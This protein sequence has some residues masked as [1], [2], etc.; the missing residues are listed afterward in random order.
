MATTPA[1]PSR[2]PTRILKPTVGWNHKGRAVWFQARTAWPTAEPSAVSRSDA[3][4]HADAMPRFVSA[5]RRPASWTPLG[6]TNVGGRITSLVVHPVD[7]DRLWVGAANGGVWASTDGGTTWRAQWS[8]QESLAIGA[9]AIDPR[10]PNI[11]YAA[12][13]EANSSADS[14]PGM[15]LYRS[16]NGGRSWTLWAD[17]REVRIPARIGA[18]VVSPRDSARLW[19]GGL[20]FPVDD[21]QGL[22]RSTDGGRTWSH[23]KIGALDFCWCRSV[24]LDP[25]DPTTIFVGVTVR[26]A[27][28]GIYRSRD[29]GATWERL[30]NGLPPG[31]K[32]DRIALAVAPSD[33]RVLYAQISTMRS[34]HLGIF[35][36][37]DG[38]D[39]WVDISGNEFGQ[40]RQ[41]QY[42]NTVAV[43]P[44]NPDWVLAGGVDLHLSRDG[45]MTW[46]QVTDWRARRGEPNY[47]HADQHAIVM[48]AAAAGRVYVGNDGGIDVSQDGGQTWAN[49][50][51]G[52]AITMFYDL[53][54]AQTDV[55]TFGG[56]CQDNGTNI[57]TDGTAGGFFDI[58]G[59]DGGWM[60]IDPRDA[61]HLIA[62]IYNGRIFRWIGEWEDISLPV[63]PDEAKRVWMV[64]IA[65]DPADS[66]V[67]VTGTFRVWRTRDAGKTWVPVSDAL[68]D[69]TISA[70]AFAPSNSLRLY[71]G[72]EN[73]GIFRSS[74]GGDSWTENLAGNTVPEFLI[75]R[76]AVDPG[77]PDVVY[78]T[79]ANAGHR[80]L[81]RSRDAGDTWEDADRGRLP[82]ISH[83]A[84]L[85][86]PDDPARLFVA[87]DVG[88]FTS[89]DAGATWQNLSG[90]LPRTMVTDLVLHRASQRLIAATYGRSLYALS[91]AAASPRAS[92]A[93]EGVRAAVAGA[94]SRRRRATRKGRGARSSRT[95]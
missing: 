40:E 78:A 56:G 3:L 63:P 32:M 5:R 59:G 21:P 82:D 94:R 9:M 11:L 14:Y 69:S 57:T 36:S 73:G 90:N 65:M 24:V 86:H 30:T 2:L 23:V 43:H 80:H 79:V 92:R 64:F 42:N 46:L 77:N 81:F 89:E 8:E 7:P 44:N 4:E 60:V 47:A 72:T 49:R 31:D 39:H 38:G 10:N 26:S 22:Y 52:L 93:P 85:I 71:V 34:Q 95:R 35:K 29:D 15:G 55:R 45:G 91:L 67:L 62:S 88:V 37:T 53:D 20:A 66:R 12:T 1:T 83:N 61:G 13:G 75:T 6:P 41:M 18:L 50:S 25:R 74:D 68:D 19:L 28:D 51:A 87:N 54:V 27:L 33:G 58:T 17:R 48:P 84:I 70:V 16:A 76:L